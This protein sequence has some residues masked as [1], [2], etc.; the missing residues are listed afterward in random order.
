MQ[1]AANLAS[2]TRMPPRFGHTEPTA[3]V[4]RSRLFGTN[5]VRGVLVPAPSGPT[6]YRAVTEELLHVSEIKKT[7]HYANE[8]GPGGHITDELGSNGCRLDLNPI[9]VLRG[10]TPHEG[11]RL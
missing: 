3:V 9:T 10:H 5:H 4:G 1:L 2:P 8:A 7:V 11:T 6:L